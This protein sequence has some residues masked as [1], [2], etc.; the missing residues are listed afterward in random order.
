MGPLLQKILNLALIVIEARIENDARFRLAL[1]QR[2]EESSAIL[3][4]Q[5]DG[6]YLIRRDYIEITTAAR[7][8]AEKVLRVSPVADLVSPIPNSVSRSAVQNS[9]SILGLIT[10]RQAVARLLGVRKVSTTFGNPGK[11]GKP[12]FTVSPNVF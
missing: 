8:V 2:F 6:T 4:G 5:I 11:I 10:E 7:A 9:L 3:T 1:V 12:P